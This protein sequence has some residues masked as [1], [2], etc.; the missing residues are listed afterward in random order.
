[1]VKVNCEFPPPA[2]EAEF[3][4]LLNAGVQRSAD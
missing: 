2:G 3:E 4:W 1:M